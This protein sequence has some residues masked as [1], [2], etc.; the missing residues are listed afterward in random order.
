MYNHCFS[1]RSG[2]FVTRSPTRMNLKINL[3]NIRIDYN[4]DNN[5]NL[6]KDYNKGIVNI[7]YNYLNLPQEID[8]GNGN[9]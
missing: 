8:F 4:Y 1:T 3:P 5:G 2:A 9:K 6:I 7:K